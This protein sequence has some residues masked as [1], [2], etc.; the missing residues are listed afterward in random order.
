MILI[1]VA[2]LKVG[3]VVILT[4]TIQGE[5]KACS[6]KENGYYLIVNHEAAQLPASTLVELCI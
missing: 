6:P 1:P 4:E 3:M 5:V 2:E